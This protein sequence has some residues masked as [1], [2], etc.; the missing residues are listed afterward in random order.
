VQPVR[1]A[2]F[3]ESAWADMKELVV[4]K[5]TPR[6]MP[7]S[8]PAAVQPPPAARP[9]NPN[10]PGVYAGPPA[11]RWYGWG[12]TTPGNNPYAPTG[13][14]PRGSSN[15]YAQTG[16]TPG[17]F[18]VPVANPFRPAAGVEPPTYV[19]VPP[20]NVEFEYQPTHPVFA[21]PAEAPPVPVSVP[22]VP[23]VSLPPSTV[24]GAPPADER[25]PGPLPIAQTPPPAAA[26]PVTMTYPA[27][28]PIPLIATSAPPAAAPAPRTGLVGTSAGGLVWQAAG[29]APT[30]FSSINSAPKPAAP[31]AKPADW[32]PVKP[33]GAAAPRVEEQR[34]HAPTLESVVRVACQNHATLAEVKQTGPATLSVRVNAATKDAARAAFEALSTNPHL[35]PYKIDFEANVAAR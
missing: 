18:P 16:A 2:S 32:S 23:T 35:R 28:T 30:P 21:R 11:Y 33:A 7:I 17:A 29:T 13:Q 22:T 3:F 12:T 20:A 4:G 25:E 5:P 15:W 14:Y 1:K 19:G 10:M 6:T 24:R 34:S 31:V 26:P 8:T 9:I 27:E